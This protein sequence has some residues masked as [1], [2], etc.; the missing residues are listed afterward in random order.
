V[1]FF[2]IA[3]RSLVLVP[4]RVGFVSSACRCCPI[5]SSPVS[6]AC[7]CCPIRSSSVLLG[8]VDRV[9]LSGLLRSRACQPVNNPTIFHHT[10]SKVPTLSIHHDNNK[11]SALSV[12]HPSLHIQPPKSTSVTSVYSLATIPPSKFTTATTQSQPPTTTNSVTTP[13]QP[14]SATQSPAV[15]TCT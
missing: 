14:T 6:S 9:H 5:R 8:L 4:P 12:K 11:P 10:N 15:S 2:L 1:I 7:R 13:I 3:R